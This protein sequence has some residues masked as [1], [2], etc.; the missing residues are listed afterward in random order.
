MTSTTEALKHYNSHYNN[1]TYH[2]AQVSLVRDLCGTYQASEPKLLEIALRTQPIHG[3][4]TLLTDVCLE[5]SGHPEMLGR[6]ERLI[7]AVADAQASE[8]T[9]RLMGQHMENFEAVGSL[10]S[11]DFENTALALLRLETIDFTTAKA[12]TATIHSPAGNVA[13][14]LIASA[15]YLLQVAKLV[16]AG[17]PS[18][19]YIGEKL[20]QAERHLGYAK[21]QMHKPA[22]API[23]PHKTLLLASDGTYV[24]LVTDSDPNGIR[25]T[26][27]KWGF[28]SAEVI[29]DWV[30]APQ[31]P[32]LTVLTPEECTRRF[33]GLPPTYG[34]E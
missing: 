1:E 17:E 19:V 13:N 11:A 29:R 18:Q 10:F 3:I 2:A 27:Y 24:G 25:V 32:S 22:S 6:R 5:I 8:E 26:W 9:V 7:R 4:L 33:G 16:L 30:H 31:I 21:E 15:E 34:K 20:H 14:D 12:H 28:A 23:S